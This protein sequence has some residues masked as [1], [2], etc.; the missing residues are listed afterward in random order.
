MHAAATCLALMLLSGCVS[1]PVQPDPIA[2]TVVTRTETVEV[3]VY[4][5]RSA[6]ELAEPLRVD[7]LPWQEAH[8]PGSLYA[9]DREGWVLYLRLLATLERYWTECSGFAGQ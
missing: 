5:P 3:P 1:T 6:P 9:L 7:E 4:A 8:T 2:P